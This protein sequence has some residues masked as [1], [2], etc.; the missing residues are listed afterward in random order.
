MS[1]Y[2]LSEAETSH[3]LIRLNFILTIL[4]T[5]DDHNHIFFLTIATQLGYSFILVHHAHDLLL[6]HYFTQVYIFSCS[7]KRTL[8]NR[9][10]QFT[11]NA[12]NTHLRAP[13]LY[14]YDH[15]GSSSVKIKGN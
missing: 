11:C 15:D 10:I 1:R 3:H 5:E 6:Q 7:I 14:C 13:D 4:I 8:S 12:V 2:I 9:I